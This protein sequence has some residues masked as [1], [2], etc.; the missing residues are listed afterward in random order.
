MRIVQYKASGT[1][2]CGVQFGDQVFS[3]GYQTTLALLEDGSRGLEAAAGAS[4]GDPI[5]IDSIIHP[6]KPWKIFGSGINY[7]AHGE[8]AAQFE[9]P[10][11]PRFDFIKLSSSIIGPGEPIVIPP[12]DDVILRGPGSELRFADVWIRRGLRG[13]ARA[14]VIGK[15]AKNVRA[16]D[17]PGH[18]FGYTVINDV[19]GRSVQMNNAQADL[20]KSF[21]T[22]CPMGPCIVTADELP[23]RAER[24]DS[25][26]RQRRPAPGRADQRPDLPA[27][28][29]HRVA[30]VDHH[31]R[32]GRCPLDGHPRRDRHV[33][34]ASC[35][36]SA[37]RHRHGLRIRNR[38]GD[39]PSR[40]GH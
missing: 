36:P 3:T 30:L 27:A 31:A 8:E 23:D 32:S 11:E 22:F 10:S 4:D 25:V 12:A 17:A 15:R 26:A 1:V 38:R 28:G 37:R 20:G 6:I 21:D 7:K 9:P 16:E 35:V 39:E 19:S 29:S 24:S 13:R 14:C 5:A 34:R 18:I 2:G 33:Q 40:C